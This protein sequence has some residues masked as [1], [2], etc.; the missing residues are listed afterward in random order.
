MPRRLLPL[1]LLTLAPSLACAQGAPSPGAGLP[2]AAEAVRDFALSSLTPAVGSPALS[3][4]VELDPAALLGPGAPAGS[5][6]T[7]PGLRESAYRAVIRDV[8]L[9]ADADMADAHTR[10]RQVRDGC[11]VAGQVLSFPASLADIAQWLKLPAVQALYDRYPLLNRV[12]ALIGLLVKGVGPY[13]TG[14][15]VTADAFD[16]LQ[17]LAINEVAVARRG[18]VLAAAVTAL[19]SP[20]PALSAALGPARD[21][22]VAVA[23]SFTA[24]AGRVLTQRYL[25]AGKV[26]DAAALL[27][28]ASRAG[29]AIA[30]AGLVKTLARLAGPLATAARKLKPYLATFRVQ[31][32]DVASAR[33][34]LHRAAMAATLLATALAPA[35][36]Q[37]ALPGE[38]SLRTGLALAAYDAALLSA[39]MSDYLRRGTGAGLPW[40]RGLAAAASA[41]RDPAFL[42]ERARFHREART[43]MLALSGALATA[44]PAPGP[45]PPAA[46]SAAVPPPPP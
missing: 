31:W 15:R 43:R 25:A 12:P 23:H 26:A 22:A 14:L 13:A 4:P 7:Q 11:R 5:D 32:D 8:L 18:E 2:G 19:P 39:I 44:E 40:L 20:D 28:A 29:Q 21:D 6:L 41:G 36:L 45:E 17:L 33:R 30:P 35:H 38:P 3:V 16:V 46:P 9:M 1:L 24:A 42:A 27:S 34:N 37:S 10:L